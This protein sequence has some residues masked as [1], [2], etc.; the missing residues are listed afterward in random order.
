MYV[1]DCYVK[2]QKMWYEN[3]CFF[4]ATQPW[5]YD[6]LIKWYSSNRKRRTWKEEIME[7]GDIQI[8]YQIVV[9]AIVCVYSKSLR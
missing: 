5:A 4:E 6:D 3:Y 7:G 9:V 1:A 2:L 8:E